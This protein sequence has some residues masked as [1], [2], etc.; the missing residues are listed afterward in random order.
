MRFQIT[1]LTLILFFTFLLTACPGPSDV[2][3]ANTN[4]ANVNANAPKANVNS[5][6][7]TSKT[8]EVATTNAAPT[9]TP[10]VKAY[11]DALKRKDDAALKKVMTQDFIKS[12]EKAMKD[13][14]GGNSLAAYA[15]EL[16]DLTKTIEVRNEKI[17]GDKAVAELKGGTYINW[18]PFE[19]AKENGEWKFTGKSPD[20][21]AVK[22]STP[23]PSAAK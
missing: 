20:V 7:N 13:E 17:E 16:E 1:F 11:Y 14:G 4:A 9:L 18:T 3:N 5:P 22:D 19:F 15:A 23:N 8:P 2:P 21:K 12:L 10:V 6:F